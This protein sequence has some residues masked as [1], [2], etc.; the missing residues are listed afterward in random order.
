MSTPPKAIRVDLESVV[1]RNAER[2][3]GMIEEGWRQARE[4]NLLT[5]EET[6]VRMAAMKEKWKKERG[7]I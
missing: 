7:L 5:P 1:Q 3:R 4:G 6:R 2:M